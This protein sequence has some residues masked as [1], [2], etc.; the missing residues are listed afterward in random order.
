ME[1]EK[2]DIRSGID[3]E[4]FYLALTAIIFLVSAYATYMVFAAGR[5]GIEYW[6]GVLKTIG[7]ETCK[8]AFYVEHRRT[9]KRG[10]MFYLWLFFTVMSLL[11]TMNYEIAGINKFENEKVMISS[12]KQESKTS[13]E[14][15]RQDKINK[16]EE[17]EKLQSE[18]EKIIGNLESSK[19]NNSD[20]IEKDRKSQISTIK[21][22]IKDTEILYD[23]RI[24][25]YSNKYITK[26]N[27]LRAEKTRELEKL[28]N[29]LIKAQTDNSSIE[30]VNNIDSK[31][32]KESNRLQKE[33][34]TSK[35]E[36]ENINKNIAAEASKIQSTEND[37][38]TTKGLNPLIDNILNIFNETARTLL[39][40][41]I[42]LLVSLALDLAGCQTFCIYKLKASGSNSKNFI[43]NIKSKIGKDE[44][45][46]TS[47]NK[48]EMKLYNL[49]DKVIN[50]LKAG[51][52]NFINNEEPKK[53]NL[54]KEVKIG[55]DLPKPKISD[56]EN[57]TAEKPDINNKQKIEQQ[58]PKLKQ[59]DTARIKNSINFIK[60][61]GVTPEQIKL[62]IKIG[63][64]FS[65][66]ID[67][68]IIFPGY[69]KIS[70][71]SSGKLTLK[72]ARAIN[73]VFSEK[74]ITEII[75]TKMGKRTCIKF[76]KSELLGDE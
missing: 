70:D 55:F 61:D 47:Q 60:I 5:T 58:Q 62:Y 25:A 3:S 45:T 15:F 19:K 38:K 67:G 16:Q 23:S 27:N 10:M 41:V 68:N 56:T 20:T 44:I 2:I 53:V 76:K 7:M 34:N 57:K 40:L 54:E 13:L 22:K 26:K 30:N 50:R 18:K 46:A 42:T 8:I 49:P 75:D 71:E 29:E 12:G 6:M 11:H 28:N 31:I 65:K 36:L 59:Q 64:E 32:S 9:G 73:T 24:N 35:K 69:K 48:I 14:Q 21:Q 51:I 72:V 52:S 1:K 33:I 4:T 43:Q 17:I 66:N 63:F 39:T 74:G 37:I